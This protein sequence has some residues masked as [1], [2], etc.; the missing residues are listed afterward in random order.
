LDHL[1][2]KYDKRGYKIEK[3]KKIES[4][5]KQSPLLLNERG[6]LRY[7]KESKEKKDEMNDKDYK[8]SL[9]I[10][11]QLNKALQK[12]SINLEE[13]S[14]RND[15]FLKNKNNRV[16]KSFDVYEGI[17]T[18]KIYQQVVLNELNN[19]EIRESIKELITEETESDNGNYELKTK[20][21]ETK[22]SLYQIN[23]N[24]HLPYTN[25]SKEIETISI[26]ENL[27]MD[28]LA[29]IFKTDKDSNNYGRANIKSNNNNSNNNYLPGVRKIN[30]LS[31]LNV[32]KISR[33]NTET[34][35][36]SQANNRNEKTENKHI[37][38]RRGK[39]ILAKSGETISNWDANNTKR[40]EF[41][42]FN[43]DNKSFRQ[44]GFII[45]SDFI[46]KDDTKYIMAT[47]KYNELESFYD[48]VS[49]K[50]FLAEEI[51]NY[52]NENPKKGYILEENK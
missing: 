21:K 9:K 27:E 31:N 13:E 6:I 40:S 18:N 3:I 37:Q 34:N 42:T 26:R 52:F 38:F 49:K 20:T 22:K 16:N 23:N 43:N 1:L 48:R 17:P 11:D 36:L 24:S 10:K 14:V 2:T 8:Y 33:Q 45:N 35:L 29:S 4:I 39:S 12:E 30:N 5:F 19:Y 15:Y 46:K 32:S 41:T 28:T 51:I 7:Y 44:S 47:K 25:N 50:D